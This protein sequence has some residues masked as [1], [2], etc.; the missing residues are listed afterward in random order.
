MDRKTIGRYTLKQE[1][2]R[3]G[4]ASVYLAEDPRFGR[5]VA[6]KIL[7]RTFLHDPQFRSRFDREARAIATLEHP[8]IVPVYDVGEEDDQPYLVMRYMAG[9]TLAD[10]L[11]TGAMSLADAQPII[12]RLASALDRAH[13]QG[14]IHRDL[15]PGNILFDG[16]NNAYLADFGIA[17]L[18]ESSAAYTGSA[19]IGTPTYMSPEQ[20]RGNMKLDGRSDIYSLGVIFY[21]MLT[22]RPPYAAETAVGVAMRH[23]SDPI[24][25][26]WETQPHLPETVDTV[27]NQAMAKDREVRYQT[28]AELAKAV[29]DVRIG[30][31]IKAAAP[32]T[33]I[34]DESELKAV[35]TAVATPV[36]SKSRLPLYAL[37]G[38]AALLLIGGVSYCTLDRGPIVV[39]T[40]TDVATAIPEA[41][42]RVIVA[43]T[44]TATATPDLTAAAPFLDSFSAD[45]ASGTEGDTIVFEWSAGG[46]ADDAFR[47]IKTIGDDEETIAVDPVDTFSYTLTEEDLDVSEIAFQLTHDGDP[48]GDPL[49]VAV[50]CPYQWFFAPDTMVGSEQCPGKPLVSQGVQQDFENGTMIWIQDLDRLFVLLPDG[51]SFDVRDSFIASSDPATDPT[52]DVPDRFLQPENGFGKLWR[53]RQGLRDEIGF[54]TDVEKGYRAVIQQDRTTDVRFMRLDQCQVLII[55]PDSGDDDNA[56][57]WRIQPGVDGCDSDGDVRFAKVTATALPTLTPTRTSTP[58]KT[59]T[60]TSTDEPTATRRATLIPAV[61]ATN[62]PRPTNTRVPATSTP[63]PTNT[64]IPPTN[65]PVR[66]TNTPIPPTN[67]PVR[68]TNTPIPPTNTPVQP[69]NTPIPPTNTPVR[70]TN[71]PIPPTNTPVRPTNTPL[72][73]TNTP[74]RPTNTPIPPTNT[75]VLPTNTPAPPTNTPVRQTNTPLPPTNTPAPVAGT[76]L[77]FTA[78]RD[79]ASLEQTITLSWQTSGATGDLSLLKQVTGGITPMQTFSVSANGSRQ[80]VVTEND[81]NGRELLFTLR[82]NGIEESVAVTLDCPYEWFFSPD[83]FVNANACPERPSGSTNGAKQRFQNGSMFWAAATDKIYVHLFN[84]ASQIFVDNFDESTMPIDSC[85]DVTVPSNKP[86]RGFGLVWCTQDAIRSALGDP[87]EGPSGYSSFVQRSR[88]PGRL[89]E[90]IRIGNST[91]SHI[92]EIPIGSGTWTERT[93]VN[94]AHSDGFVDVLSP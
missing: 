21:E 76:L 33:R 18:A 49:T 23:I 65:T 5:D 67:T 8:A 59:P 78:D 74:V 60:A 68:P 34:I 45:S 90:F 11:R 44:A 85:P 56:G 62:T 61:P 55:P 93:N 73:P 24:P 2:G 79:R 9:G 77:S 47:L 71:T 94:G 12:Q 46:A 75:P 92:L 30:R 43:A 32:A 19:I 57:E 20:A 89:V 88:L 26:A 41:T 58:T 64:S 1:L 80:F 87:I 36:A 13:K 16:D 4:M 7:P 72:P 48:L 35:E 28:A 83:D 6:I 84:G 51:D 81:H 15:K 38:L 29:S 22:G 25:S 42:E 39:L 70:P 82:G 53:E 31:Q 14:I 17:H 37:L 10:R 27:V 54:A 40:P 50:D 91:G 69:T 86:D 3:G 52:I 63:R 66:P